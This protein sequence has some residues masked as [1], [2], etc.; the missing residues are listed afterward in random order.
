MNI[1]DSIIHERVISTL[2]ED[3]ELKEIILDYVVRRQELEVDEVTKVNVYI[4][5]R[6]TGS[7]GFTYTA[8]VSIKKPLN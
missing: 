4:S 6:D 7:G 5:Q 1:K 8:V 2:I 3:V